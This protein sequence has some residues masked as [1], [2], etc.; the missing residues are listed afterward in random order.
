MVRNSVLL[1]LVICFFSLFGWGSNLKACSVPFPFFRVNSSPVS[2]PSKVSNEGFCEDEG[3]SWPQV[4]SAFLSYMKKFTFR[5]M[6]AAG[7][8]VMDYSAGFGEGEFSSGFWANF[9]SATHGEPF[10]IGYLRYFEGGM[11]EPEYIPARFTYEK[12]D[13]N[14][15]IRNEEIRVQLIREICFLGCDEGL[16]YR[17][18]VMSE[19]EFEIVVNSQGESAISE[20]S[21]PFDA[22]NLSI[23]D[24]HP[25]GLTA[26]LPVSNI[27]GNIFRL[28]VGFE[29]VHTHIGDLDVSIIHPDGTEVRLLERSGDSSEN[30]VRTYGY[31]GDSFANFEPFRG[32]PKSGDWRLKVVDLATEDVGYLKSARLIFYSLEKR[33]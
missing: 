17:S 7:Y 8:G 26:I 9:T 4:E 25:D 16:T 6:K 32:R 2:L 22:L 23:P 33:N 3:T 31:Q 30:L 14:C 19:G 15:R 1:I 28:A 18:S 5:E 24:N 27:E 12:V 29:I 21:V 13:G 10:D 11:C 20:I